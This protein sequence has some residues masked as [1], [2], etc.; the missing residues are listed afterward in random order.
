MSTFALTELKKG[1]GEKKIPD[2]T[3]SSGLAQNPSSD[4]A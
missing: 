2:F 1:R 3:D 4:S